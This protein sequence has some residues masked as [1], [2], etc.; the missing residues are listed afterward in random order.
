MPNSL[1]ETAD[2]ANCEKQ[3]THERCRSWSMSRVAPL[4]N[5]ISGTGKVA[6]VLSDPG[7]LSDALKAESFPL[8]SRLAIG[9][10]PS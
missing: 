7:A 8:Q 10:R 3:L 1:L 5:S 4:L 9:L 6:K 2:A